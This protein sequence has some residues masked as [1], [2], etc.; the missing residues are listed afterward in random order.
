MREIMIGSRSDLSDGQR[1]VVS[2]GSRDVGVL[3][4]DGEVFAYENRCLH[5]GGPVCEGLVIGKVETIVDADRTVRGERFSRE[6]MHLVCPWHG[7][8]YDL[9][10]GV[11]ATEPRW[12]LR[13][14]QVTV[15]DGELYLVVPD[16]E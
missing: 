12:R 11:C 10:T 14:Y 4:H 5:Q 15:R 13:A 8:E 7:W 16:E 9:R 1:L 6:E 2:V 3:E